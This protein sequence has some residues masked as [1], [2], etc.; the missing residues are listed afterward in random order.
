MLVTYLRDNPYFNDTHCCNFLTS[1]CGNDGYN[2][3]T[4]APDEYDSYIVNPE[5]QAQLRWVRY[6]DRLQNGAWGDHIAL[7]GICNMLRIT[8]EV[9]QVVCNYT[10]KTRVLNLHKRQI[11][12][13]L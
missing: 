10:V 9:M 7:Q 5:E 11:C 13:S 8:V 6:L 12:I 2:A 1:V 4:E 3:D